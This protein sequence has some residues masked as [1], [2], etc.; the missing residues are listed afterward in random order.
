MTV[1]KAQGQTLDVAGVDLRNDCFSHGQLYVAC[2]RVSSSDSLDILQ[3]EGKTKNV[4][5]K[6]IF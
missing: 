3:P 4:V 2:S 1:N 5:Y 6:E